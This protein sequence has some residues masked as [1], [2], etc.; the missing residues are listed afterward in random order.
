MVHVLE[1]R[2]GLL[3]KGGGLE[4]RS[5]EES[6]LLF[7]VVVVERDL[8]VDKLARSTTERYRR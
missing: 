6:I 5:G 2:A 3:G 4:C 8:W 1:G 7:A